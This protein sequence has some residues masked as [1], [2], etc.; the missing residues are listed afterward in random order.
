M[1]FLFEPQNQGR[2]FVSGLA[3]KLLGWFLIGLAS[4]PMA[5]V[6]EWFG[7]KTTQTVFTD[8]ASKLVMTVSSGLASKPAAMVSSGLASKPAATVFASLAS[9]PMA[10]VFS[11]LASK[12]VMTVSP[13]L[14]SKSVVGFL[15]EPQNQGGGGFPGLGLKTGS[16]GLVIWA[17]KSPRRFLSFGLKT[18]QA[19][20]CRLR[21]KTDGRA[22]AWHTYRDLATRFAW[23]QVGL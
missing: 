2:G 1:G 5:T 15:V 11:S 9:K 14:T 22:M 21:H 23:K 8:L 19:T 16:F 4:K 18:M 20:V 10:T 6:C 17:S 3:S 12:L 7:L 13:S